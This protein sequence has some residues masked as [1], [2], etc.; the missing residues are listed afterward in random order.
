MSQQDSREL[1]I[2]YFIFYKKTIKKLVL[3]AI[4]FSWGDVYSILLY[5]PL[6]YFP[7]PAIQTPGPGALKIHN[8]L[9]FYLFY[10]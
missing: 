9:N 1:T 10:M 8:S 4:S 6:H 3:A 7:G 2:T 5:I